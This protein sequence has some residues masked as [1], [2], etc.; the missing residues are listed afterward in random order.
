MPKQ[1]TRSE[2]LRLKSIYNPF[3]TLL[4]IFRGVGLLTIIAFIVLT[5]V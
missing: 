3:H 4:I 1:Y 2:Y 5:I